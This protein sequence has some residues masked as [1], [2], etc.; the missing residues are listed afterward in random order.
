MNDEHIGEALAIIG[1]LISA[2][3]TLINNCML[4][5]TLAMQVWFFSNPVMLAWFIGH[6]LKKW[7]GGLSIDFMIGLYT[8]YILTNMYGLL[9]M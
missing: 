5:H 7:N 9:A 2:I 6:R 3:A 1:T 4:D 8:F